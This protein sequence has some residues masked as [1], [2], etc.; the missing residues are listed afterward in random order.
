MSDKDG[1]LSELFSAA[2][3]VQCILSARYAQEPDEV[4]AYMYRDYGDEASTDPAFIR[5]RSKMLS[6]Q[7]EI[8][9]DSLLEVMKF[10]KRHTP[11]DPDNSL[12]LLELNLENALAEMGTRLIQLH[13]WAVQE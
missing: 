12:Y 7:T 9:G 1:L 8:M 5:G 6:I 13:D 10:I 2:P 4:K 3:R 11:E